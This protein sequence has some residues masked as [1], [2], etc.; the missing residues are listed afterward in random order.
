LCWG[1]RDPKRDTPKLEGRDPKRDDGK[2]T[3]DPNDP[4]KHFSL[5]A[6]SDKVCDLQKLSGLIM[7]RYGSERP[8]ATVKVAN[9]Q[10][11]T[12][13]VLLP[14]M[15]W[16]KRG[17]A[18]MAGDALIGYSNIAS[19]DAYRLAIMDALEKLPPGSNLILAG[20]SLGGIEAQNI[21]QSLVERWGFKVSQVISFGAPIMDAEQPGTSY[22]NVRAGGDPLAALD[23]RYKFNP[24]EL[25]RSNDGPDKNP[26]APNGS[27]NNYDKDS[28]G[29]SRYD[30]AGKPIV[31]S[32]KTKCLEIDLTTL[33]QFAAPDLFSRLTRSTGPAQCT[34]QTPPTGSG[35]CSWQP[36]APLPALG[37]S[38]PMSRGLLLEDEKYLKQLATSKCLV[39]LVRDSSPPALRWIGQPG[40]KPK[41]EA[42]KGKTL[43]EQDLLPF[44]RDK[45]KQYVGLASAKYMTPAD[46]KK[47]MDGGY[48]IQEGPAQLI[49]DQDGSKFYSDTDLHGVYDANGNSAWS[50]ELGTQLKCNTLDQGIQ[51]PP[52][53]IW[54]DRNNPAIA[55]QNAGPQI[56]CDK[57]NNNCK[58]LTAILPDGRTLR[59][60]TLDQMKQLYK[61]IGVNW[62]KVYPG[63]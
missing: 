27:H 11:P 48:N 36:K 13:L 30:L 28:S 8:I 21:V 49:L 58:T 6:K 22:L 2:P 17:Q 45:M 50:D 60:S 5:S 42:I 39:I 55:G 44:S 4:N 61:A 37:A 51:H 59:I 41:P 54:A 7:M 18:T 46:R 1:W 32:L 52:H 3:N 12:Y 26:F 56:G 29:L 20:H 9:A 53:D 16:Q 38:S 19:L 33:R 34:A 25:L 62:N 57:D 15:E 10:R 24:D 35:K 23:K 63:Q 14:G 31:S 47:L 40:Y 43:K